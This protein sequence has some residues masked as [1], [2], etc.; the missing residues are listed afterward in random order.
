MPKD[1]YHYSVTIACDDL[2]VVHCLRGLSYF[3]QDDGNR[4]TPWGGTGRKDWARNNHRSTFRF[5]SKKFRDDFLREAR[6]VLPENVWWQV[7]RD[8]NDPPFEF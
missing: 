2:A 6:R 5:T 3:V 7:D 4:H 1:S 8:D